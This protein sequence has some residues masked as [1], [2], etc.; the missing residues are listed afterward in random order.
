M[1]VNA[2]ISVFISIPVD[3]DITAPGKKYPPFY[4][5]QFANILFF[6]IGL[7][8]SGKTK[9]LWHTHKV[10]VWVLQ[11][12]GSRECCHLVAVCCKLSG[13]FPLGH[14]G[15]LSGNSEFILI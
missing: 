13:G 10:E 15:S 11:V 6:C 8:D 2:H 9:F 14:L 7:P 12:Q 1:R 5:N 3:S 4:M